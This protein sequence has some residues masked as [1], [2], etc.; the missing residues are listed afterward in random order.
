M[1]N[2]LWFGPGVVDGMID[3][4]VVYLYLLI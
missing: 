3:F 2:G 1:A 4:I